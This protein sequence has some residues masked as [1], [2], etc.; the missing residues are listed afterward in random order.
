[1][2]NLPIKPKPKIWKSFIDPVSDPDR[3]KEFALICPSVTESAF[4]RSR[5][6]ETFPHSFVFTQTW[7][8]YLKLRENPLRTT[9]QT[10]QLKGELVQYN[11]KWPLLYRISFVPNSMVTE[12]ISLPLGKYEVENIGSCPI[13]EVKQCRAW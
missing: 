5:R 11:W 6:P 1:M 7:H 9:Q 3:A 2:A 10:L 4:C 8:L 13:T 12:F